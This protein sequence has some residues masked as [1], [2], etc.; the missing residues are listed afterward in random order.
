M[1]APLDHELTFTV[2]TY[3]IGQNGRI[4][5]HSLMEY[6]Q[7]A[8]SSHA[9][10]IGVGFDWM[11]GKG[12]YWVLVNLR[13]EF[14]R[15]PFY[16]DTIKIVTYPSG[17]DLLKAFREFVATDKSGR[18]VLKASSEWMVLDRVTRSVKEMADLQFEFPFNNKRVLG[19][20]QRLRPQKDSTPIG[21]L[22]VPH[23]SIDMNGHVNNCEYVRWGMDALWKFDRTL[24][25]VRTIQVSFN[26]EVR[27]EEKL[28][29]YGS[30]TLEGPISI[31]GIR[32]SD[33]KTAFIM[34]I[35]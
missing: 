34:E 30:R 15:V 7:E 20:L 33:S 35:S 10:L 17:S 13:I 28:L 5:M 16:D 32:S 31:K 3:D 12:F 4:Q 26:A 14:D 22:V 27:E 6:L 23:S 24:A 9:N 2:R 18:Q 21:E 29:L 11:R 1:T 8:A 19:D 25:E